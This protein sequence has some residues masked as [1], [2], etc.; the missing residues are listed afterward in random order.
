[1]KKH[2]QKLTRLDC[3]HPEMKF[4]HLI[5]HVVSQKPRKCKFRK[6]KN[7]CKCWIFDTGT[8]IKIVSDGILSQK[9]AAFYYIFTSD[10]FLV[11]A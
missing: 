4:I 3:T 1:M 9:F 6:K 10:P 8:V 2:M 5:F 11:S 7:D